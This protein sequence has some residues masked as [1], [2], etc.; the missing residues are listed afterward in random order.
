LIATES[1]SRSAFGHTQSSVVD[2]WKS[3]LANQ[4]DIVSE[5]DQRIGQPMNNASVPP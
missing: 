3:P 4:G 1:S 5:R 2:V